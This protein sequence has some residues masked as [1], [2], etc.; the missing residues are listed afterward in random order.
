MIFELGFLLGLIIGSTAT[1]G[2]AW[3]IDKA[4]NKPTLSNEKDFF[5]DR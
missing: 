3:A 2:I 4:F 1:L 5:N